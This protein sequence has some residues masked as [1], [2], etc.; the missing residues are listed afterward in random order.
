M[1]VY[2]LFKNQSTLFLINMDTKFQIIIHA[3]LKKAL[4]KNQF[5]INKSYFLLKIIL[6]M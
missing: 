2:F 3:R 1:A 5:C 6:K 4:D